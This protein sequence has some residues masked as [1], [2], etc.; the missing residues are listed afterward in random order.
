MEQPSNGQRAFWTFI[1]STLA[2]PFFA[3]LVIFLLSVA[4]GALGVG[5]DSLKSAVGSAKVGWAAD[6]ALGAFVWSAIPAAVA[7]LP[8]AVWI[9]RSGRLPWLA[10]AIVPAVVATLGAVLSGGTLQQHVTPIAF[11]AASVGILMR[12][13]LVRGRIV[14]D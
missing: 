13:L 8:L 7:A 5:P 1:I 3:A 14:A 6:R 11:I 10:A 12:A 9:W 4:A 2:G